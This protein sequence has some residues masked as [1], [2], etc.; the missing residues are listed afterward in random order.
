M[1]L[2]QFVK[3]IKSD[4]YRYIGR[5]DFRSLFLLYCKTPGYNYSNKCLIC[6]ILQIKHLLEIYVSYSI[7][8]L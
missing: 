3:L 4:G 8:P 2:G 5:T 6:K 1:R 7:Y